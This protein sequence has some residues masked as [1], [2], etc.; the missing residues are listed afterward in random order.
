MLC[1]AVFLLAKCPRY[2]GIR[3]FRNH[4]QD[5]ARDDLLN[6]IWVGTYFC[7]LEDALLSRIPEFFCASFPYTIVC[8]QTFDMIHIQ[9]WLVNFSKHETLK[10]MN[11]QIRCTI[12]IFLI[13][14]NPYSPFWDGNASSNH[15]EWWRFRSVVY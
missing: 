5:Y 14:V 13:I 3:R 8:T 11:T 9:F 2:H 6:N 15:S 10:S 1:L 7:W 4:V 12:Y